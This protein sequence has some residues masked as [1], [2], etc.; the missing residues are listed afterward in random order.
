[1]AT[2]T[3]RIRPWYLARFTGECRK[4]ERNSSSLMRGQAAQLRVHEML[5]RSQFRN[6]RRRFRRGA[7]PSRRFQGHTS[8]QMSQPK[9]FRPIPARRP[10]GDA[11]A[12][13]DREISDAT[14]GVH[15]VRE[16]QRAGWTGVKATGATAAAVRRGQVGRQRQRGQQNAEKN[17]RSELLIDDAGV[18]AHPTD[19]GIARQDAL[20]HRSGI[21][22]APASQRL[23]RAGQSSARQVRLR[24]IPALAG[25]SEPCRDSR[26]RSM[27]NGKSSRA[28]GRCIRWSKGCGL[29]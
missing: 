15:L 2:M 1:M 20:H 3:F 12:F 8:W 7:R 28:R 6:R 11:A 4:A 5:A 10:V 17:P 14:G 25:A 16:R 23:R 21:D 27:H 19:A 9:I 13:F 18:L 26:L 24:T 29:S 22:V